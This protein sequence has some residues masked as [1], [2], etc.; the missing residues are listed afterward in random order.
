MTRRLLLISNAAMLGGTQLCS[1]KS[2]APVLTVGT[3]TAPVAR[4]TLQDFLLSGFCGATF[5]PG[6]MTMACLYCHVNRVSI[7]GF[8]NFGVEFTGAASSCCGFDDVNQAEIQIS[9]KAVPPTYAF[10]IVG[11]PGSAGGPDG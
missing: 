9:A 6:G 8:N 1:S 11:M 3:P 4:V 7:T 5:P 10:R 2:T